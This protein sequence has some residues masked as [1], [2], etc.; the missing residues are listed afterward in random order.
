MLSQEF[1]LLPDS[2]PTE[3]GP[4]L[5]EA[6][7]RLCMNSAQEASACV[8]RAL[9][10]DA[11]MTGGPRW[12]VDRTFV[13][14]PNVSQLVRLLNTPI[15]ELPGTHLSELSAALEG[16]PVGTR[17]L[18]FLQGNRS[19]GHVLNALK[20]E[21]DNMVVDVGLKR[22]VEL[23]SQEL[24]SLERAAF[25]GIGEMSAVGLILMTPVAKLPDSHR[26]RKLVTRWKASRKEVGKREPVVLLADA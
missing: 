10:F 2:S 9:A 17:G 7:T 14:D 19:R 11:Q 15:V 1:G 26:L 20:L 12:S 5:V 16:C 24:A 8:P 13:G 21:N 23:K 18:V 6:I 3:G 4:D 25:F 22:V